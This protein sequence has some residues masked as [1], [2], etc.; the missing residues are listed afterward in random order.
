MS[1]AHDLMAKALDVAP[2]ASAWLN[3]GAVQKQRGRLDD[4]V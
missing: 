3:L 4:A 1:E 2:S